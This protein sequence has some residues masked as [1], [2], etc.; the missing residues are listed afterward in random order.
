MLLLPKA[1]F[2]MGL[3]ISIEKDREDDI[4][5]IA[6]P[7]KPGNAAVGSERPQEAEANLQVAVQGMWF[8]KWGRNGNYKK[9]WVRFDEKYNCLVW[10]AS[11]TDNG[12]PQGVI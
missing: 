12:V 1:D 6:Q 4:K 10:Q 3:D 5:K 2:A 8:S 11:K 9:R 7:Q